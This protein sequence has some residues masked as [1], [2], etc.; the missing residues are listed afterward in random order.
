MENLEVMQVPKWFFSILKK[1]DAEKK[2]KIKDSYMTGDLYKAAAMMIWL[3][4]PCSIV[5]VSA[6]RFE[7][8]FYKELDTFEAADKF[9]EGAE[10]CASQFAYL[11]RRLKSA[12]TKYY[13]NE[14][15]IRHDKETKTGR[16]L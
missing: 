7:F 3:G 15:V 10:V 5:E 16:A 12:M 11:T 1:E 6:G 2:L 8:Q 4:K 9:D 13:K 14:A